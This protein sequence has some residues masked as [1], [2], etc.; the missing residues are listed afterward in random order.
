MARIN[1]NEFSGQAG[2]VAYRVNQVRTDPAVVKAAQDAWS[3][4]RDASRSCSVLARET[5]A[6][7][8]RSRTTPPQSGAYHAGRPVTPAQDRPAY[9]AAS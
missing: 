2:G 3:D 9:P 5:N 4:V 7:W 1:I 8:Q 6:A